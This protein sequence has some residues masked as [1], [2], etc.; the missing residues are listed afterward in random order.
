MMKE[1]DDN[2]CLGFNCQQY[3]STDSSVPS[4]STIITK[5]VSKT[6]FHPLFWKADIA[7]EY[8]IPNDSFSILFLLKKLIKMRKNLKG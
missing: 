2:G 8:H 3:R 5:D 7:G 4:L 1:N 6:N